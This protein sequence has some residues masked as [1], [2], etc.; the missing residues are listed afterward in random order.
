MCIIIHSS[1]QARKV[2][3]SWVAESI[4][5]IVSYVFY[6]I[7][8]GCLQAWT[9]HAPLYIPNVRRMCRGVCCMREW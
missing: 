4:V 7:K 8:V 1:L 3:M 5:S 2:Q 6:L 9:R